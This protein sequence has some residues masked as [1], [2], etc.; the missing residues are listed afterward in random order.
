MTSG[1]ERGGGSDNR[2]AANKAFTAKFKRLLYGYYAVGALSVVGAIFFPAAAAGVV[3]NL[4]W[5]P[6]VAVLSPIST[7]PS[8]MVIGVL[9]LAIPLGVV[10]MAAREPVGERIRWGLRIQGPR[11]FVLAYLIGVPILVLVLY[12]I[13]ALPST[14]TETSVTYGARVMQLVVKQ[15][16]AALLVVPF[17]AAGLTVMATGIVLLIVGPLTLLLRRIG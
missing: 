11:K 2:E 17:A 14:V 15:P 6:T 7:M 8:L 4:F 12:L 10:Y 9:L 16:L 3:R 13:Y 5:I 1:S